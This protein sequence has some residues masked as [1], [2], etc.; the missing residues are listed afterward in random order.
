M[1]RPNEIYGIR[2]RRFRRVQRKIKREK[3]RRCSTIKEAKLRE[4]KECSTFN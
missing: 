3:D 4:K 2:K 1:K